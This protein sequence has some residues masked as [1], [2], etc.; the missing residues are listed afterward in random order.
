MMLAQASQQ[1]V[2]SRHI[3]RHDKVGCSPGPQEL[4]LLL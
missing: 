3:S 1:I 2:E 4:S